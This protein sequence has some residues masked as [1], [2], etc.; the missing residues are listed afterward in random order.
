MK[1][2]SDNILIVGLTGF[3]QEFG[4]SRQFRYV[5]RGLLELR[6]ILLGDFLFPR[7]DIVVEAVVQRWT[8]TSI[9]K[10]QSNACLHGKRFGLGFSDSRLSRIMSGFSGFPIFLLRGEDK[11]I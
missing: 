9:P 3:L 8:C 6:E 5:S 2:K 10:L 7:K 1:S 11:T 4:R